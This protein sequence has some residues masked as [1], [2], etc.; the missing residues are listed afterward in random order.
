MF[1]LSPGHREDAERGVGGERGGTATGGVHGPRPRL[2]AVHQGVHCGL[3]GEE[4]PSAHA[5]QQC[6]SCLATLRSVTSVGILR[7]VTA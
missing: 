3:S 2:T 1:T 5:H 7:T 6:R 4:S